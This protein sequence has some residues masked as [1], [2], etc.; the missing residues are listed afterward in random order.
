MA[1]TS[2]EWEALSAYAQMRAK[3]MPHHAAV[4]AV[5]LARILAEEPELDESL[6]ARLRKL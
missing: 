2:N 6:V 4:A 1:L 5:N 3:G